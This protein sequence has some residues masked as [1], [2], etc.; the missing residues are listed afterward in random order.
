MS[1]PA[2][3][4]QFA[5][6]AIMADVP[7]PGE[8]SQPAAA[9]TAP[10][11][12][13]RSATTAMSLAPLSD[14][15]TPNAKAAVVTPTKGTKSKSTAT[16]VNGMCDIQYTPEPLTNAITDLRSPAETTDSEDVVSDWAAAH[17]SIHASES[18]AEA[19]RSRAEG[20][21]SRAKVGLTQKVLKRARAD[22][23]TSTASSAAAKVTK[24]R[25]RTTAIQRQAPSAKTEL[26]LGNGELA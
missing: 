24:K 17:S 14:N 23:A 11:I 13:N 19:S 10:T 15:A 1:I 25:I 21:A 4:K 3:P 2:R 7:S 22:S 20:S 5:P 6:T 26:P 18:E 12:V 8:S 16:T 9:P